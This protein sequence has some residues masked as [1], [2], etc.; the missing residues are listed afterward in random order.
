MRSMHRIFGIVAL[1]AA[2]TSCGDVV[3]TGRAPAY[4]VMDSLLGIQ[5]KAAGGGTAAATLTSDVVVTS[6]SPCTVAAPCFVADSGQA[7]AHIVLKDLGSGTTAPSPNDLNAIT[8][9]RVHVDYVRADGRKTQGVDVPYSFDGAI[10]VTVTGSATTFGFPLVR[11]VAK[12]E[13]PLVQLRNNSSVITVIATVTFYG[14][15]QAGNAA[16]V[17]GMIQIDFGNYP[18]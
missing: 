6:P 14:Q 16:L 15:D 12:E 10:T 9:N 17:K 8:I 18:D 13:A 11:A 1:V 3:R 7:V 2:T 5:G 4:L